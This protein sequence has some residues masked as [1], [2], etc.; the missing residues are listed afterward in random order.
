MFGWEAFPAK[1]GKEENSIEK[2]TNA[3]NG[4]PA[5]AGVDA[6]TEIVEGCLGGPTPTERDVQRDVQASHRARCSKRYI[7]DG[8]METT[9]YLHKWDCCMKATFEAFMFD[10]VT[11]EGNVP[12]IRH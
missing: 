9:V 8:L 7:I 6:P 11:Q 1:S 3:S 4:T 10:L 12:R 2:E 5:F